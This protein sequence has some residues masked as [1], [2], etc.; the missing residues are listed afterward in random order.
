MPASGPCA[1]CSSN[2]AV[3]VARRCGPGA[4]EVGRLGR[5]APP[6]LAPRRSAA[7]S[8]ARPANRAPRNR[9]RSATPS[10]SRPRP[11]PAA[12]N[13]APPSPRPG[14]DPSRPRR[15]FPVGSGRVE[16]VAGHVEPGEFSDPSVPCSCV[17]G[18]ATSAVPARAAPG[19]GPCGGVGAGTEAGLAEEGSNGGAVRGGIG[20]R[21]VKSTTA[22]A[23]AAW[24]AARTYPQAR[25]SGAAGPAPGLRVRH[26]PDSSYEDLPHLVADSVRADRPP[27]RRSSATTRSGA[28]RDHRHRAPEPERDQPVV[29]RAG[30]VRREVPA[31]DPAG[32]GER[33]VRGTNQHQHRAAQPQAARTI[34]RQV[35]RRCAGAYAP[36]ERWYR[37][38]PGASAC[39]T[40]AAA[41]AA[42]P[43]RP[44]P[45]ARN[46]RTAFH[47]AARPPSTAPGPAQPTAG[48]P[49]SSATPTQRA[50]QLV[51]ARRRALPSPSV[52]RRR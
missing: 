47:H 12:S 23:A 41:S 22:A 38:S 33:E 10:T 46:A 14:Q 49:T 50:G 27:A 16:V 21:P 7:S 4:G 43:R 26:V 20:G 39:S 19:G 34:R 30:R 13:L 17:Q 8:A 24:I 37:G 44:A 1:G 35:H 25:R 5:V 32:F 3:I 52:E 15:A 40:S 36:S 51:V 2:P 6:R 11:D 45:S 48:R 18:S 29:D 42:G 28:E 9:P 31:R